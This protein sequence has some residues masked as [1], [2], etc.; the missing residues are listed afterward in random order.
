[1]KIVLVNTHL[2]PQS[3]GGYTHRTLELAR[4]LSKLGHNAVL[5]STDFRFSTEARAEVAGFETFLFETR[6]ARF[7][8]PRFDV[9]KLASAISDA[10]LIHMMGYWSVLNFWIA[11]YARRLGVPY[12]I[13][14]AG[15]LPPIGRSRV[16]KFVFHALIGKE[17]LKHA[18]KII[19][20]TPLE[21]KQL[22][23]FGI[24]KS[25]IQIVPNGVPEHF[26]LPVP[27]VELLKRTIADTPYVLFIGRL[28]PIKGPDLLLEAYRQTDLPARGIHLVIAGPDEGMQASLKATVEKFD[29]SKLVHMP[30][31]LDN[32]AKQVAYSNC[33]FLAITSRSEAMS[34][35][36]LEAAAIGRPVLLTSCCGFDE[37][38]QIGGGVIS[39]ITVPGI[40]NGL[41]KLAKLTKM[42]LDDMGARLRSHVR[43]KYTWTT[44]ANSILDRSN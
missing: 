6:V 32:T 16:L 41:S 1:M 39:P 13:S 18:A 22:E 34:L 31:Y 17:V 29:L 4:A 7:F 28:N 24:N 15:A 37:V 9:N 12:V 30:G 23:V 27:S 42:E 40:A 8:I 21:A 44:L 26:F 11:R 43:A 33:L 5:V 10:N 25:R 3:G 2:D 38:E 35:V 20:I 36:A 14:P 19:A